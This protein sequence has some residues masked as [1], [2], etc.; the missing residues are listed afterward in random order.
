MLTP[1]VRTTPLLELAAGSDRVVFPSVARADQ[2]H[3]V[4]V[5]R[6]CLCRGGRRGGARTRPGRTGG[7]A[8]VQAGLAV[9]RLVV[10]AAGYTASFLPSI[11]A[12]SEFWTSSPTFFF[13]RVGLTDA[14]LSRSHTSGSSARWRGSRQPWS[15]LEEL[16]QASLFVYWIHVEMVYGFFSRPL[17]RSLSFERRSWPC[18]VFSLSAGPGAPQKPHSRIRRDSP[19]TQSTPRRRLSNCQKSV[20]LIDRNSSVQCC[21]A[22]SGQKEVEIGDR[23]S[24]IRVPLTRFWLVS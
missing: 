6:I 22:R 9:P 14:R 18:A 17:S 23:L 24:K 13:L 5:G 16:G 10:G 21:A 3:A 11:Y 7:L 4:S 1:I 8:N 2:F 12:K 20:I 15:P 19:M